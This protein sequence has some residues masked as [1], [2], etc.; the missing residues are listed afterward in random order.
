VRLIS[1]HRGSGEAQLAGLPD[2]MTVETLG[3]EFD[4]GPD[5]FL[6]SAAVMEVCDLVITSDTAIAHLAGA[7]GR[8]AWVALRHVPDWRWLFGRPE[9]QDRSPWYPTLR[10]YR[11]STSGDWAGL[12]RRIESNVRRM[13]PPA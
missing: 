2:G 10:L 5:A 9:Y 4:S 13:V 1:L 3:A 12:F 11:Q 6:D 7:L 8:P